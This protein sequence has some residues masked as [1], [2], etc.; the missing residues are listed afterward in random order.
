MEEKKKFLSEENYQQNKKKIKTLYKVGFAIGVPV[1]VLAVVLLII[2]IS[3][4]MSMDFDSAKSGM[5]FFIGGGFLLVFG[6]AICGFSAQLAVFAHKR[7][8]ASFVATST[9]PVVKEVVEDVTPTAGKAI[10]TVVKSVRDG[11]VGEDNTCPKCG[12]TVKKGAKFCGNC[13]ESLVKT[14]HCSNC[15]AEIKGDDKYCPNCGEKL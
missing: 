12:E 3:K 2:G 4:Q 11:I 1:L 6:S 5:G 10:K 8:I 13:G 15:G 7:D 14:R 9:V